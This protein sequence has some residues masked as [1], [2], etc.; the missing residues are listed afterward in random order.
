MRDITLGK[1]NINLIFTYILVSSLCYMVCSYDV[2]E[3]GNVGTRNVGTRNVGT[4]VQYFVQYPIN[5]IS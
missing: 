4:R 1:I 5:L 2:L 3:K